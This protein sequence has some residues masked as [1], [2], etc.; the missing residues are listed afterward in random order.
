MTADDIQS[1]IAEGEGETIE[2]KRTTGQRT[3]AAKTVCAFLNGRGGTVV[4]GVT[5]EGDLSG[6]DVVEQ[7]IAQVV[8][9]LKKVEPFVPITP[10]T[11]PLPSGRAALVLD[12]P[13]GPDRPYT[14]DGRPYVRQGP[15]TSVMPRSQADRFVEERRYRG[16]RW[17]E[18]PAYQTTAA[19]LDASEVTRTVEEAIR[20]GRM[21][22]PGTR[23]TVALLDSLG[24]MRDGEL[25]NA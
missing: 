6:L 25:L 13:L 5:P 20:R 15:T 22:E 3:A 8:Q 18:M 16:R 21:D 17:E 19:D 2:F 12:V 23:N 14:Y 1:L 4:F 24:L 7:T 11:V 9:E 10:E